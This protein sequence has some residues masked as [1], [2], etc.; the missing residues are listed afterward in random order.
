MVEKDLLTKTCRYDIINTLR[1]MFMFNNGN[2]YEKMKT[3]K[4]IVAKTLCFLLSTLLQRKL[5][6]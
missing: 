1:G 4:Y 3:E 2:V 6:G 5:A